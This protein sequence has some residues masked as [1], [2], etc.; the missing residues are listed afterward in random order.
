[1]RIEAYNKINQIYQTNNAAKIS[2]TGKVSAS[3]KLEISQI[4]KDIQVAKAAVAQTEDVR[5]DKVNEIKQRMASGTYNVSAE[6]LAD[7]LVENYFDQ[8]I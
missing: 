2:K 7:K 6:E 1:M 3:D 5:M 4:G 8:S